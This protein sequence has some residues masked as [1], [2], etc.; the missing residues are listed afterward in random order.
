MDL[1][2]LP[3]TSN[4]WDPTYH[5]IREMI[6]ILKLVLCLLPRQRVLSRLFGKIHM[7]IITLNTSSFELL[8][9]IYSY[10]DVKHL[11]FLQHSITIWKYFYS[12]TQDGYW[13]FICFKWRMTISAEQISG[14]YF[15]IFWVLRTWS[16][17]FR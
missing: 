12:A 4:T 2:L 13:E 16:Q 5:T 17:I 1:S 9:W 15:K 3:S 11:H 6:S 14:R 8:Q 10:G 7:L